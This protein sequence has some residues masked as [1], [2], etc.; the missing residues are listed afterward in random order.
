MGT[1]ALVLGILQFICLGPIAT[2]LAIIFGAIGV[3]KANRGQATNKGTALWGMWLGIVGA[4]LFVIGGILFAVL[5][6]AGVIMVASSVDMANNSKTG[7]VDGN[8]VMSPNGSVHINERCSYS[9]KVEN[10]DTKAVT[11]DILVAGEGPV[12]CAAT[13]TPKLVTFQVVGG[14]AK[15]VSSS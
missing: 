9:G 3:K 5:A 2:I 10:V 7:L 15:I 12:E 1:A 13:G 11:K 14:V 4:I 8:Y 6:S